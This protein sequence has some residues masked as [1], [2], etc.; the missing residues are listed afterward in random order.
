V[1]AAALAVAFIVPESLGTALASIGLA[2][3]FLVRLAALASRQTPRNWVRP[4][5]GSSGWRHGSRRRRYIDCASPARTGPLAAKG[6]HLG[7]AHG[8]CG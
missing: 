1:S 8:R 6:Q 3:L 2:G 4:S 7:L 5:A